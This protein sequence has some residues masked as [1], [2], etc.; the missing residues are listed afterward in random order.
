MTDSLTN[1]VIPYARFL[2]CQERRRR[3]VAELRRRDRPAT[4]EADV[5]PAAAETGPLQTLRK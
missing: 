4:S 2:E 3:I 5:V 1:T